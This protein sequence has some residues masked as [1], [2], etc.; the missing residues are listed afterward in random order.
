MKKEQDVQVVEL[1]IA[2]QDY[3]Q[4]LKQ[5]FSLYGVESE[6]QQVPIL[7]Y[8]K[9]ARSGVREITENFAEDLKANKAEASVLKNIVNIRTIQEEKMPNLWVLFGTGLLAGFNPCSISMLLMLFSL[10]LT[11]N[12]SVRKNGLLYLAGKY[13]TY[14]GLGLGIYFAAGWLTGEFLTRIMRILKV[15][16]AILFGYLAFMNF[17]DFLAVRKGELGKVRMQLPQGLRRWNHKMIQ[18]IS[19]SSAKTLPLLVLG[20]GIVISLGEF[21]CT[22]QIYMASILY[23]LKQGST[24]LAVPAFFVYVT[25]MSIPALVFLAIIAKT[26]STNRISEF[27]LANM[28]WVKLFNSLLF[29]GF[30]VYFLIFG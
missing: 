29:V 16:L 24:A 9:T 4:L 8:G 2:E 12:A 1:S 30:A 28:E 3:V 19:G 22:G 5:W 15:V 17:L 13:L 14:V 20:L 25:A 11:T 7:F 27:M 6:R 18:K 10:I 21:F 23:L 26:R